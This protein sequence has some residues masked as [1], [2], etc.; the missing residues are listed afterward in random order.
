[1]WCGQTIEV[2]HGGWPSLHSA[3]L[4]HLDSCDARPAGITSE[5][6]PEPAAAA[7][8]EIEEKEDES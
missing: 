7:A 5:A 3:A 2:H 4:L 1:M 6:I 8:D